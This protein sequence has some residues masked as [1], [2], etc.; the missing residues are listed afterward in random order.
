[1][2]LKKIVKQLVFLSLIISIFSC[3][4]RVERSTRLNDNK[5]SIIYCYQNEQPSIKNNSIK[6]LSWNIQELGQ[7]KN[8]DEIKYIARLINSYDIVGVQEVVARDPRGAQTVA[9]IVDELNRM[10][11]KWDYAISNPTNSPSNKM[12]ERYAFLWKTSK[13]KLISKP[14]LDEKLADKCIREPYIAKFKLKKNTE[15]FYL[16]NFHSRVHSDMPENE[17]QYFSAY[18]DR[19]KSE[20]IFILGDFNLNEKHIVWNA[21]YDKG[22]KSAIVDAPT[23]LKRK[24]KKNTYF[25]HSIDNIYYDTKNIQLINSGRIDFV[26]SCRN[27]KKARL[28]S[29]HLPVFIECN[30]K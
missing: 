7:S 20:R 27:L 23:T 10:G 18:P 3:E 9:K 1:M 26:G 22:Y 13:V 29:D 6:I 17:I 12:S 4:S 24:C 25:N 21:L 5:V 15:P 14:Y 11:N 2:K 8:D 30:I 16:V 19:L 28:I